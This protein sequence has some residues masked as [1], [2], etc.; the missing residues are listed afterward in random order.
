M[1]LKDWTK[2]GNF[3][4]GDISY[5]NKKNNH[6]IH[7]TDDSTFI[8]P[9]LWDVVILSTKIYTNKTRTLFR[10]ILSKLEALKFAKQYMRSH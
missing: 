1:A 2:V 3:V 8:S 7:I 6:S 10:R 4:D 9:N 5:I